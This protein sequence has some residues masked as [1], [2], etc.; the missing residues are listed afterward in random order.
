MRNSNYGGVSLSSLTALS[1]FAYHTAVAS[2]N[3]Q[4]WP[5]LSLEVSCTGCSN[6]PPT[7]TNT[8]RLFF[9]PPYQQPGTGGPTC[10]IPGQNPTVTN[11]W[12][13]WDALNGC[14]WDNGAELGSGGLDTK[15]LSYFIAHHPDAKIINPSGLGGLRLAVGFASPTDQ[16]DGNVDMVTVGVRGNSTS[17]DFEPPTCRE[18]DGNGDFHSKDGRQG[19][20]QMDNDNCE[21][22]GHGGNGESDQ[23]DGVDSS[24]RGDGQDFHSTKIESTQFDPMAGTMTVTGLGTT[25]GTPVTFTLVAVETGIGGLGSVSLI[26][27]DGYS[28]AGDLLDGSITLN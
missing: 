10:A 16:F 4:Q 25:N 6:N 12:Q 5:Y 26:F 21:E 27:S 3:Q 20:V 11:Q 28:I 22:S 1:Y 24:N 18:A 8:D 13:Q 7:I 23:G 9:E 2:P 15:P 17:Y 14:W 19:D